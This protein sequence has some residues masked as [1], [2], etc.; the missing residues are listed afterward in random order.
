MKISFSTLACPNWTLPQII[1]IATTAG[2]DGIEFRFVEGEDSLWKLPAFRGTQLVSTKRALSDKGL[3]VSCLDTSCRFHS[4]D[5]AE[6]SRWLAEGERMSDLAAALGAP[7]LRVFGDTIQPGADRPSTRTWIAGSIHKLSGYASAKGVEIWLET[8]GDFA[9]A[10]ESAAVLAEAASPRT[11]VVW[12]PA[13]CF[14]QAQEQPREGATRL[15]S[16]I[17]HVHIKDFRHDASPQDDSRGSSGAWKPML[18]GEGDFPLSEVIAALRHLKYDRF[19]SFEW[20]RKWHP[21]IADAEVALPHFV[22]WFRDN[23]DL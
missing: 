12:D 13:N 7:A 2:Y 15:G 20:E 19:L 10:P 16:S 17:R 1:A 11:G 14:L 8:H 21:E 6:R 23:R 5:V 4:A 3:V 22:R 9:S 18:T